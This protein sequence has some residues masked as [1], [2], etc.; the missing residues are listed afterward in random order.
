MCT[1]AEV[2]EFKPSKIVQDRCIKWMELQDYSYTENTTAKRKLIEFEYD[3]CYNTDSEFD[4][5]SVCDTKK[6]RV[7]IQLKDEILDLACEWKECSFRSRR[8]EQFLKHV[9]GHISNVQVRMKDGN[10]VFVCQW[11]DCPYDTFACEEIALHVN[12]HSYHTKLKSIGSNVRERIKLPKCRRDLDWK[13]IIETPPT[14]LCR[15]EEC[16]KV[17]I[18]YQLY[19]YHV[20]VHVEECP[21]GSRVQN[22][23][24]CK[25]TGCNGKYPNLY[26]LRDHMRCHTKEKI[27]ACPDCGVMFASKTKFHI[28]CQRQIPLDVQGFR[29][30]HCKKFYP[31]ERILRDHMRFH[32]FNYKCSLCD[33]SCES[34]AS[35]AKHVR[36]RH[37]T[38]RTFPCQLCTHAAKSQQDLD[39]HMTVHTDGPNFFCQ[40][41][42]CH[43]T[44]K[45]AYTLDRHLERA[46]S[47]MTRWYCCHECPIKYRTSARLTK[48][49]IEAH[50]LQLPSGHKRFHYKQDEDGCY[51]IQMVRY[52]AVD[53]ENVSPVEEAQLPDKKYKIEISHTLPLIEV[54]IMED[55]TDARETEWKQMDEQNVQV[56]TVVP[57]V[58]GT[59]PVISNILISIEE[60]DAKGNLIKREFVETQETSELPPSEEPPLIL[61]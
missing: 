14:H 52:E 24:E 19:L 47:M 3:D 61:I 54:K 11:K 12:Y 32:V 23:V 10:E 53:E 21:R 38:T 31:T 55:N 46:H 26:K 39:Y 35:L 51:R 2:T 8:M 40:F 45:G 57:N 49:L 1:M 33:M 29:C 18:N 22:G 28:H 60:V 16:L 34:P 44:C 15:W 37:V 56:E 43:Y 17:F 36:Y 9:S 25:W 59:I 20:T 50:Q 4:S 7:G 48:H 58:N 30:S 41:E 42:G 27:V 6:R 13:N 5:V